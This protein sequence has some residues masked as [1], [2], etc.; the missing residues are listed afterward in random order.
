M[1]GPKNAV[2]NERSGVRYYT[3]QG[4]AYPSVTSLRRLAGMP[5]GLAMWQMNQA[6]KAAINNST[7]LD[8]LISNEGTDE[9]ARW[10]R[11]EAMGE[12]D[13]AANRGTEVHEAAALRKDPTAVPEEIRGPLLQYLHFLS[14]ANVEVLLAERQVF[15]LDMGYAGSLDS[16]MRMQL[17]K[18]PRPRTLVVDLKT[19]K[20]VYAEFAL[21]LMYYTLGEFVGQDDVV[22]DEATDLLHSAQGMAILHLTDTTWELLEVKATPE[23]LETAISMAQ[24]AHWMHDHESIDPLI[25]GRYTP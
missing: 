19:G 25:A 3:W 17:P 1:S 2:T 9:A 13:A 11:K 16:L 7:T 21:Q 18:W 15:N 10:L 20:N 6:I 4:K 8:M 12:R 22:D 5:F 24:F 14:Y 23:L